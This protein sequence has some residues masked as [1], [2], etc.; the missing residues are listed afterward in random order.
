MF[1]RFS[2]GA[3][4]DAQEVQAISDSELSS[5]EDEDLGGGTATGAKRRKDDDSKRSRKRSTTS[6][7]R[8]NQKTTTPT[9]SKKKRARQ[10]AGNKANKPRVTTTD[11]SDEESEDELLSNQNGR[12]QSL[13]RKKIKTP[14]A[15]SK[16]PKSPKPQR[17]RRLSATTAKEQRAHDMKNKEEEEARRREAASRQLIT[18]KEL[19]IRLDK[20]DL[21]GR[22]VLQAGQARDYVA[23]PVLDEAPLPVCSSLDVYS[24]VPVYE[25]GS[26]VDNC[27]GRVLVPQRHSRHFGAARGMRWREEVFVEDAVGG[28]FQRVL[29]DLDET[30]RRVRTKGRRVAEEEVSEYSP[31]RLRS[32]MDQLEYVLEGIFMV[33]QGLL[34]GG[35]LFQLIVV[36]QLNDA[37]TLLSIY[38]PLAS[39]VRRMFFFL[40]VFSF[41]GVCDKLTAERNQKLNWA[42]RS[43]SERVEMLAYWAM[44]SCCL[45][46]SLLTWP[47]VDEITA[48]FEAY[49]SSE[50]GTFVVASDF[51]RTTRTWE[52]A[53]C[54]RFGFAALGWLLV[55]KD[56]NRDLLR[57]R[58]RFAKIDQYEREIEAGREQLARFTGKQ[59]DGVPL[60]D[61]EALQRTL[62][63]GLEEVR[64]QLH[65]RSSLA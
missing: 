49:T 5:E 12:T 16:A 58:K 22:N 43:P 36:T 42:E 34:S 47:Y 64:L 17:K 15:S 1:G 45:V 19:A 14:K 27:R 24:A 51:E 25:R 63:T 7:S 57:G 50:P 29:Y 4:K 61:L 37:E 60:D 52:L 26:E 56:T 46:T 35:S 20:R 10:E 21:E 39:E 9:H 33:G 32:L 13:L 62:S 28:R 18:G 40:S 53:I 11:S 41:V 48:A 65:I 55:C 8:A 31:Q 23:V 54:L 44:F 2:R 38:G 30:G 6:E 59:L 3:K